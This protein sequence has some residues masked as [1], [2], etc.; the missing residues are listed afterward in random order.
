MIFIAHRGA[1]AHAP[2]N[3]LAAFQLACE[4]GLDRFELDIHQTKDKQLV[5]LHD[6]NAKKYGGPSR[7]IA[8]LIFNE[9]RVLD[10]GSWF[11]PKFQEERIPLL[12]EVM[13]LLR[14]SAWINVEVKEGGRVYPGIEENLIGFLKKKPEWHGRILASSFDHPTLFKL[15]AISAEI[16]LGYLVGRT[17]VS[18]ALEEAGQ[19]RCESVHLDA[20]QVTG[21]FISLAHNKGLKVFVYTVNS[22][23]EV[24]RLEKV[25]VDGVFT[26]YPELGIPSWS[27]VG[28]TN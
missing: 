11:D 4:M 3:T 28:G 24:Q 15:R 18:Q 13:D 12:T 17:S 6:D 7:K 27:M 26:N 23:D 19:L 21:K 20:S 10:A 14:G 16:A 5:V 8:D 25:G 9:V 2:E 1:S 22:A